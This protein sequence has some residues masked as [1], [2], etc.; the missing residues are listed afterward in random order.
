MALKQANFGFSRMWSRQPSPFPI[1]DCHVVVAT[2]QTLNSRLK[3]SPKE[4]EFLSDFKVVVFDEAHRSIA[5]TYTSVMA[6][7]G[8]T[9]RRRQDEPFLIGLT[10]TPYRGFDEVETARLVKRYGDKR[11]DTGAFTSDDTEDVITELQDMDVLAQMDQ[12][13]IEG[14]SFGLTDAELEE[15][16]K[17]ERG[18]EA[19]RNL[20]AWLPQSAE[21]R[22]AADSQ[23]TERILKAYET[24]IEPDWPTLTFATS[25]EHA[26]TLAALLNLQGIRA[27]C[28]TGETDPATRKRV[29]DSFRHGEITAL[30]NYNVFREGFDAPKTRAIIVARPVYSPNLYF[31]M[32][33]RGLRGPRNGGDDR[34]LILNV[35]DTI[36]N[37]G[38]ELAFTDLDWL[39]NLPSSKDG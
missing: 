19:I 28:V 3:A 27:R 22:I 31:Q 11:L 1:N 36:D 30:V 21:N 2:V 35:R 33:G 14:G 38:E 23:R 10:A 37:F 32:I 26:Q 4:Y 13:V 24:H 29:V 7:I 39:W 15:I 6:E 5:P 17:F 9:H 12:K 34:C 20:L 8:I 18:R 25:V 16:S